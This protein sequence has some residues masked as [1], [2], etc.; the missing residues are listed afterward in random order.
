AMRQG[1][2]YIPALDL[3]TTVQ[4]VLFAAKDASAKPIR[5]IVLDPGHGGKDPG[6]REGGQQEKKYTLLL[7]NELSGLLKKAGFNVSLTRN[8][9]TFIELEDRA[10][11]ARRRG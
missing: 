9:D 1:G 2:A 4:P 10:T 7:A 8:Y 6:N 5:T 11:T 3:T